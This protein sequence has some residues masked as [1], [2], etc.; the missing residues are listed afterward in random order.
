MTDH[1][2]NIVLSQCL[3][4]STDLI[5]LPGINMGAMAFINRTTFDIFDWLNQQYLLTIHKVNVN[6]TTLHQPWDIISDPMGV[7]FNHDEEQEIANTANRPYTNQKLIHMVEHASNNLVAFLQVNTEWLTMPKLQKIWLHFKQ[8]WLEKYRMQQRV[9]WT[10]IQNGYHGTNNVEGKPSN[11]M[12][13]DNDL[14]DDCKFHPRTCC[15]LC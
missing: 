6:D 15:W 10:T 9:I 5:W 12:D 2:C 14:P 1:N 11:S 3:T 4:K 8:F 13:V 7:L